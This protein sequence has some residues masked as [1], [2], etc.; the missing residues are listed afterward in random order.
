MYASHKVRL[1]KLKQAVI[2]SELLWE[3]KQV[4]ILFL[5]VGLAV[6]S[7]AATFPTPVHLRSPRCAT[8][9]LPFRLFP[10]SFCWPHSSPCYFVT[11]DNQEAAAR[12]RQL[13]NVSARKGSG[14]AAEGRRGVRRRSAQTFPSD[15]F[16]FLRRVRRL[17]SF[18]CAASPQMELLACEM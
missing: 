7:R 16:V 5:A 18:P 17:F 6:T 3:L 13:H 12:W 1:H 9:T 8:L 14:L 15:L 10:S 2:F 11:C 4:W